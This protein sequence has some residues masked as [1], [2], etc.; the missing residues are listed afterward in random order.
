MNE[1]DEDPWLNAGIAKIRS[2]AD[3]GKVPLLFISVRADQ[4]RR[5]PYDYAHARVI[6]WP[7]L[8]DLYLII[9]IRWK[10]ANRLTVKS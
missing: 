5:V 2:L 1:N 4:T 6:M 8:D 9:M 7:S 10:Q 3:M